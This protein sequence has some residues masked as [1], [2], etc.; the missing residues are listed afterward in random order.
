MVLYYT[1]ISA[2]N[3]NPRIPR[4]IPEVRMNMR[5]LII[6]SQNLTL[7]FS[8][9]LRIMFVTARRNIKR[10]M[11]STMI[12]VTPMLSLPVVFSRPW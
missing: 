3:K 8:G 2:Q 9:S 10:I 1:H 6:L 5:T 12:I 11:P 4:M 7:P